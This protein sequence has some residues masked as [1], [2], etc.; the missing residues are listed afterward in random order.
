MKRARGV[1]RKPLVMS[2]AER[3]VC[4]RKGSKSLLLAAAAAEGKGA[5]RYT[6]NQ[7]HCQGKGPSV[8]LL[9]WLGRRD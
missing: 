1:E 6:T 9:P 5:A 3:Q 7:S 2:E 8:R 4:W